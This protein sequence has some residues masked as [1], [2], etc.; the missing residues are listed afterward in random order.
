MPANSWASRAGYAAMTVSRLALGLGMLPYGVS[1]LFDFQFQVGASQYAKPLGT[2]SGKILTWAFLGYSPA[3]QFLL[4]VFETFPAILLL[5][6]RTRRIGAVL[7]FPVVL[8]VA[9][10]NYFLD[11]WPETQRISTIFLLLNAFLL[12]YDF[13]LFVGFAKM[14]PAQPAPISHR[15]SRIASRIA[16]FVVPAAVIVPFLFSFYS[17]I[18]QMMF[19]ITDFIGDRQINRAGSWNVESLEV[20][21]QHVSTAANAAFYFDFNGRFVFDDGATKS[22]GSFEA[23]KSA[24]TFKLAGVPLSPDSAP[25]AGAYTVDHERLLL[26][27]TTGT[28]QIALT[29]HR[30]QWGRP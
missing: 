26:N 17:S 24:H 3:F 20:D 11:L 19:P 6:T 18:K 25:I 13:R 23:N 8:N 22:N 2:A 4:G 21:R 29:L 5:F 15:G 9:M 1:K 7:L 27:G 12:A 16:A 10:F 14:L 30:S 28:H